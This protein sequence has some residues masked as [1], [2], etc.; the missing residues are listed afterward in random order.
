MK[1]L[2]A[3]YKNRIKG[4][5]LTAMLLIPFL[6]YVAARFGAGWQVMVLLF[7]MGLNMLVILKKG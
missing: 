5:S 2:W 3:F 4:I 1:T 6:L 7:L